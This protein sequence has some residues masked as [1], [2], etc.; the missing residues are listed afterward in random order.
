MSDWKQV[1]E[2][3]ERRRAAA[4]AMGGPER[5]ERLM[6]QRG[7]LDARTRLGRLFDPGTFEE[8]G[9]LAGS[10]SVPGDALVAGHGRIHGRK[11]LAAAED[12]TV[13][14]GSIGNGSIA[15][16]P[17]STRRDFHGSREPPSRAGPVV[18]GPVTG[19]NWA[20]SSCR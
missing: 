2:V 3:L 13:L 20:L 6:T 10:E 1:L 17:S 11:T 4:R 7:K 16:S 18:I 19:W 9:A 8:L 12:F 14:G 15:T 5:V